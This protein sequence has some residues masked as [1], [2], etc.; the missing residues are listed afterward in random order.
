VPSFGEKYPYINGEKSISSIEKTVIYTL[1]DTPEKGALRKNDVFY[2]DELVMF[3]D[4][5]QL[6]RQYSQL[7]TY[8]ATKKSITPPKGL[9]EEVRR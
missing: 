9:E 5:I 3:R 2:C 1:E 8:S 6:I 4:N 7:F